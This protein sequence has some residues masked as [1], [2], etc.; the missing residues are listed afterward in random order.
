MQDAPEGADAVAPADLLALVVGAARVGDADL[1]DRAA[2]LRDLGRDLR[3]EAEAVLFDR[4]ALEHLAAEDLVAGLHVGQVQ[5]REHVR[6]RGEHAV[7]D[8]VPEVEHAVGLAAD[9]ARAEHHVGA[10]VE[11]GPQAASGTPLG[12]TRDR[13][14]ARRRRRPWRPRSP[15]A[16]PRPCRGCAGAGSRGRCGRASRVSINS[17]VPSVEPSSTT[18]ISL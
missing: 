15:C 13:R 11:D 6:E 14:P 17:R 2:E 5:V 4:D 18:M 8:V 12:R 9:E 1:V 7:A 3:L 16:A 10:L